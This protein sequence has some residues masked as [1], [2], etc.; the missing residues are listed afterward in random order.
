[1]DYVIKNAQIYHPESGS[2]SYYDVGVKNG[3]IERIDTNISNSKRI[4][5]ADGL[6]LVPG[7]IDIHMHEDPIDVNSKSSNRFYTA[8]CMLKMGVTT[9]IGGNCGFSPNDIGSYF[10]YIDKYG[11]PVNT[12]LYSG[13]NTIRGNI[14][15][16]NKSESIYKQGDVYRNLKSEEIEKLIPYI[17]KHMDDG[18]IGLSFGLEYAPGIST[19]EVIK[20]VR[21]LK[22]YENSIFSS[23]YRYDSDR[24]LESVDESIFTAKE[25]KIPYQFSHIGSCCAF[26]DMEE[27]LKRIDDAISSGI[28]IGIDCYPYGA[29]STLIGSTVFD[30]GCFEKWRVGYDSVMPTEGK[31][32]NQYC[33]E[34]IFNY[35]RENE[36]NTRI[37]CFAM[38]EEEVYSAY[39]NPHVMVGSDGKLKDGQGHPR[40]AGTFPRVLGK[41]VREDNLLT[42][43]EAVKKMTLMPAN[44]LG[45]KTKGRIEEGCDADITI[46][47]KNTILDNASY[48]E[49]SLAPTGIEYVFVNGILALEKGKVQNI[50]A[51]KSLRR[52]NI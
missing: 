5:D 31:Y 42:F 30:D 8:E 39:K 19:D 3:R 6:A 18:S 41:L 27:A 40:G 38:N 23:H 51:G 7:F 26:G 37:V 14:G 16:S 48:L 24:A 47:N 43:E 2:Y 17:R 32:K 35:L 13:Y 36:P 9:V 33:T 52:N 21:V 15:S 29:F 28:E 45:L 1:M 46:L 10:N 25:T 11:A 44:R 50:N 22:D 20:V 12:M 49:P 4:I 34:E